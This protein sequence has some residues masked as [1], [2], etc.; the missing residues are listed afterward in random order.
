M[1]EA[2]FKKLEL[3]GFNVSLLESNSV[4]DYSNVEPK[5]NFFC[6][7]PTTL[8]Q[9]EEI[10][11]VIHTF[12][13]PV[14]PRGAATGTTGG[15]V[16]LRD[17]VI[18]DLSALNKIES[19]DESNMTVTVECGVV[20]GDL[21]SFCKSKKLFY[22]PDPASLS[23]CT[24]GGNVLTNAGGPRALKYGVTRDFVL[25]LSGY[26]VDG[27]SFSFGGQNKKDVAGYDLKQLLIGS[28]GTLGI[29]THIVLKVLPLPNY[30]RYVVVGFDSY[31]EA[32]SMLRD[33]QGNGIFPSMAEI[34]DWVC[35]DA[36]QD[37]LKKSFLI[38]K[39]RVYL[40]LELDGYDLDSIS[41]R[42][43]LVERLISSI[44]CSVSILDSSEDE[45]FLLQFRRVTSQ[46]LRSKYKLKVSHDVTVPV[47]MLSQLMDYLNILSDLLGIPVIGY[48]HL[49]DGNVHVNFLFDSS[50]QLNDDYEL[51]VTQLF[52]FVISIGGTLTGEH[53]IGVVKRPFLPLQFSVETRDYFR[54]IKTLFDPDNL[55]NPDKA[56]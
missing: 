33:V 34:L 46:A 27:R 28:E 56:I 10:L 39:S 36:V 31:H 35:V 18:L 11:R 7:S 14:Y 54:A 48:G 30:R 43:Q 20:T 51:S 37:Y 38:P 15:V 45:L 12:K 42:I 6:V 29:I 23:T 17:G 53:G 3:L 22:P 52:E 40:I 8:S 2:C 9:I 19:V 44:S 50:S 4:K 21:Q 55:L 49:G 1:V 24:I 13:L 26:W 25:G 47:A 16:P 5:G 41:V 32:L